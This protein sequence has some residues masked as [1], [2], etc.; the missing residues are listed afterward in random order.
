MKI[1]VPMAGMGKRL[2]PH[3]LLTPKPL[4]PIAGKP[5]VQRLVEDI[6]RLHDGKIDEIAFVTGQF[7][8]E[9]ERQLED[10]AAG[11][12]AKGTIAY[13]EEALG[14]A[15]AVFCAKEAMDG[16]VIIAFADTIFRAGFSIDESADG[17]IW[18]RKVEDP[19]RYGVVTL[20][21]AGTISGMV[22]K[23]E[24]FVSDL[25]IIGIYYVKDGPGLRGEIQRL[26][27]NNIKSKG[28]F[29][30]TDALENL[31]EKGARFLPGEVDEW[32]DC[33]NKDL[34]LNANRRILEEQSDAPV[35]A[36]DAEIENATLLPPCYVG[37]GAKIKHSV[38]GPHASIGARTTVEHS[39]VRGSIIRNDAALY[40]VFLEDSIVGNFAKMERPAQSVSLGDYSTE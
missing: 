34:L 12:G 15:H 18:V 9:T 4:F 3:T 20:D 32:L 27:D 6:A 7:G 13:Q 11:L 23:P 24:T 19:R 10:V 35:V 22:E 1:I 5:I 36:P 21:E 33:G 25:A 30:L 17:V 37:A 31:R 39:V 2:R 14:T 28:E 8:A 16:P 29:Q 26:L 38:V 40:G